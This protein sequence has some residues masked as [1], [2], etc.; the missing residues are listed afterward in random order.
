[1]RLLLLCLLA[2][3]AVALPVAAQVGPAPTDTVAT[4]YQ[5]PGADCALFPAA[6]TFPSNK[7]GDIFQ[8]GM[9]R[10]TPTQAQVAATERALQAVDLYQV[11]Y[12]YEST[13]YYDKYP[14][15]I[16]KHLA[17][18]KRQYYGFYDAA[19]NPC[20]FINFFMETPE[21]I[22]EPMYWL[23]SAVRVYDGGWGFWSVYYNL[24]TKKFLLYEHGT[25]G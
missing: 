6:A 4:R 22:H 21:E 13:N 9:R 2:S 19:R 5:L 15:I 1:M 20:L 23:R 8:A 17:L 12:R 18:Y 10:F 25:E 24:T 3:G 14:A 7:V 11:S 16:K